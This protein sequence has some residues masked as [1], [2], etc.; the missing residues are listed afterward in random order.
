[1]PHLI[2][3]VIS[4]IKFFGEAA[5]SGFSGFLSNWLTKIAKKLFW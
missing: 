5:G 3:L 1:M 4:V 2:W